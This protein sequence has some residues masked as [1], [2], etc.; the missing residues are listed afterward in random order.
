[1]ADSDDQTLVQQAL[2]GEPA[3]FGILCRRYY[4]ALVAIAD[5]VLF[6]HHLAED[7]AQEALVQA[8]QKLPTLKRPDSF[9]P[10]IMVICRNVAKDM[11]RRLPGQRNAVEAHL[12]PGSEPVN[13]GEEALLSEALAQLPPH[14]REVIFLRFFHGMNYRQMTSA[15]GITAKAI[16][17][18]LRRGKK[19]IAVYMTRR[20]FGN[21]GLL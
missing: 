13:D 8:C 20:G 12:G 7:A 11:L 1:M 5:A 19:K 4:S 14:L 10:W 18:R 21:E 3:S 17:G 9:G 2:Q 15:L 16:D 6:D